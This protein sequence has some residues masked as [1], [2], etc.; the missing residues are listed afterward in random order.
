M[1]DKH[2]AAI[3]DYLPAG[4][5]EVWEPLIKSLSILWRASA[6]AVDLQVDAS[7]LS[8]TRE[9]FDEAELCRFDFAWLIAREYVE[10]HEVVCPEDGR[11]EER[12]FLTQAGVHYAH[13]LFDSIAGSVGDVAQ[14]SL[15]RELTPPGSRAG[16]SVKPLWDAARRQLCVGETVVKRLTRVAK[17]QERILCEFQELGWPVRVVDPLGL[18]DE[19]GTKKRI[20]MAV[21]KLNRSQDPRLILF[22]CDGTGRG[23]QWRFLQ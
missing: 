20:R 17:H 5:M 23:V 6:Y 12:Y 10:R 9:E 1:I 14:E 19:S 3:A 15:P 22:E 13:K 16:N 8:V 11:A 18:A 2:F 7:E 4:G 21:Y